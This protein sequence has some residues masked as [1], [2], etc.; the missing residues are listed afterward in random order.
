MVISNWDEIK[1]VIAWSERSLKNIN[2]NF[3][4]YS[5]LT[6]GV[7]SMFE[8]SG[9][10]ETVDVSLLE[11][12]LVEGRCAAIVKYPEIGINSDKWLGKWVAGRCKLAGEPDPYGF[13]RDALVQLGDGCVAEIKN[14]RDSEDIVV[15]WNCWDYSLDTMIRDTAD[16]IGKVDVS[17][18]NLIDNSRLHPL[19]VAK[20]SKQKDAINQAIKDAKDGKSTTI[21][22]EGDTKQLIDALSNKESKIEVLNITD[23][24]EAVHIQNISQYRE[25]LWRWFWNVYGMDSRGTSKRA[26]QS[27]EEVD[28]GGDL[29]MIIP[30]SRWRARQEEVEQV[31]RICN[32]PEAACEFST[33]WKS[34]IMEAVTIDEETAEELEVE[35]I[36]TEEENAENEAQDAKDGPIYDEDREEERNDE[37]SETL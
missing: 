26:Q 1:E 36:I 24:S 31:R 28:Q 17:L 11:R 9:Y 7:I 10:P 33:C 32:A 8:R 30:M 35:N 34:R 18:D 15:C 3:N 37:Q 5:T 6:E 16:K 12:Y 22:S 23:P 4:I 20:D 19:P 14:W 2:S 13:G 21:F 27:V 29:S 25:D